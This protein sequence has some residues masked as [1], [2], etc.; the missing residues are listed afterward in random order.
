MVEGVTSSRP[1]RH[2]KSG[3]SSSAQHSA[4]YIAFQSGMGA[5][6][7][8]IALG[9]PHS[10]VRLH[11]SV[12]E[13]SPPRF[14]GV[15]L[16]VVNSASKASV[17]QQELSSLLQKGAIEEI[18]QS[19]IEREFFSRYF[20]VLKNETHSGSAASEPF[21]LQ[22]EVQDA[23]DENDHVSD[24][25]RG[26]VCHYRPKGCILSHPGCPATQEVPSV[27]LWREG[28]PIQGPSLWPGL[29]TENFHEVHGCCTGPLEVPCVVTCPVLVKGRW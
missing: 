26:L 6:T 14:D 16:T 1:S 2:P 17:L 24:S 5:P 9:S 22:R 8:G 21:S 4:S 23:D 20:L 3:M 13:E 15:Q 12:W 29:G 19:D 11:T 28:L 25:R 10:S 7:R 27:C 18:P